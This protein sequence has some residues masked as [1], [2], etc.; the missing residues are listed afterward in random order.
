M[1]A[2]TSHGDHDR[3]L[4]RH[5]R[6]RADA[7]QCDHILQRFDASDK[8][9]RGR[10]GNGVDVAEEGQ[11][12]PHHH[13]APEWQDVAGLMSS[14]VRRHLAQYVDRYR[15]LVLGALAPMVAH[16]ATGEPV[17]LSLDNFDEC[18]RPHLDALVQSMYRCGPINLQ[19]YLQ[20]QRRLPPL[21]FRDLSAERQL[22]D[23]APGAA[24]PV[25][26]ERRGEGGE[27]EFLYQGRKVEARR[28]G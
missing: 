6:Q 5:L 13:P 28:A 12:G 18:G 20:R 9:V 24:V 22:R 14:A 4:H 23:P 27:T 19:K 3:R 15:A 21:A 26:P 10:T 8:V 1:L 17:A 11:L 25:L 7:E 2:K 16:P